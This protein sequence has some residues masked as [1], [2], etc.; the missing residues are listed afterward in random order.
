LRN[1]VEGYSGRPA[2]RPQTKFELRGI[3]LGHEVFDLLY[4]R[5]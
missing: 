3:K 4:E 5:R 1:R 2:W